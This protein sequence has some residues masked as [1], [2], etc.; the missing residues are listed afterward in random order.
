LHVLASTPI[1]TPNQGGECAVEATELSNL[2]PSTVL[3]VMDRTFR[4]Y[5]KNF[6]LFFLMF[7]IVQIPMALAGYIYN[8]ALLDANVNSRQNGFT[9]STRQPAITSDELSEI[10]GV[11]VFFVIAALVFTFIRS[12]IINSL[13]ST[14][15]SENYL[16]REASLGEAFTLSRSR[17]MPLFGALFVGGIAFGVLMVISY[18]AVL[19]LVGF[20][21]LPVVAY[22]FAN[23]YFFIVPVMV[24]ER[25]DINTGTRR[26]ITLSRMRFWQVFGMW[27]GITIISSVIGVIIASIAGLAIGDLSSNDPLFNLFTSVGGIILQPLLPIGYVL[28]YYDSR[29]R[30]EGLD[31]ALQTVE[32]PEPRPA[33][34]SSPEPTTPMFTSKDAIN[35]VILVGVG[36]ALILLAA[37]FAFSIFS[38]IGFG[39]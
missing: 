15:T 22:Y 37:L 25:V 1:L 19:C 20:V 38:L 21:L 9:T 27:L 31:L 23:F 5:R 30:H 14:I 32:S 36:I 16:G 8:D 11:L 18:V 24:L 33:D 3:E 13:V 28:M 17:M 10:F 12:V 34:V 29:I 7:A 26:A 4:I 39:A 6:V 35:I 2:R